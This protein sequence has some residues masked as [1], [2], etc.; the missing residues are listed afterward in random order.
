MK[1]ND[2]KRLMESG[3]MIA[4][5]VI[6]SML[7]LFQLPYGGAVTVVSMLP[8]LLLSYR[9]GMRWGSLA[10]LAYSLVQLLQGIGEGSLKGLSLGAFL[11]SAVLDYLLAFTVLC[12]GG[13][14][15]GKMKSDAAAFGMGTVLAC[16]ARYVCHILSGFLFFGDYAEWFFLEAGFPGGEGIVSLFTGKMLALLYSVIYNATF[17]IPELIITT[18]AAVLVARAAGHFLTGELVK[19]K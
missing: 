8:M 5:A 15:K 6:L 14:L 3:L 16:L 10:C 9:Y 7:K 11:G 4:L 17:M 2:T 18:A 13:A 12:L 19:V 1:K